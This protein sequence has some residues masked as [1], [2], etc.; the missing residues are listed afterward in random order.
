VWL[1]DH[2][3]ALYVH[4]RWA[5]WRERIQAPF[6]QIAQHV[7]LPFA[8]SLEAADARLRPRI[9]PPTIEHIVAEL[10]DDWL[11]AEADAGLA[12][13]TAIR[14]A[15]TT[16]LVERLNGPRTWLAEAIAARERG[17]ETLRVRETHRVV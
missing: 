15:Y 3:A 17:P 9:D 12:D 1:I 2:G 13:A 4:H 8:A 16:Y 11:G 6:S 10:P 7:L 14:Q 5:N